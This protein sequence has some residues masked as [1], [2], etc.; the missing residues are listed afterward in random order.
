MDQSR[1]WSPSDEEKVAYWEA[2]YHYVCFAQEQKCSIL[3]WPASE[4]GQAL[5]G[6]YYT[7]AADLLSPVLWCANGAD[8]DPINVLV[9]FAIITSV[10][11]KEIARDPGSTVSLH[12]LAMRTYSQTLTDELWEEMKRILDMWRLGYFQPANYPAIFEQT[13]S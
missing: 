8:G 6:T 12:T 2:L 4:E 11:L 13:V 1:A 7:S 3:A 9:T 5:L 10:H